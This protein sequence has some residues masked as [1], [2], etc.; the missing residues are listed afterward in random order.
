MTILEF[1]NFALEEHFLQGGEDPTW[2]EMYFDR[3]PSGVWIDLYVHTPY[4]YTY[5]YFRDFREREN[6][7]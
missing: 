2:W 4:I 3:T 5:T 1:I 7:N 6:E